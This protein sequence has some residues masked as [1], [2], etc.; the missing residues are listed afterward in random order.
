MRARVLI[1]TNAWKRR[2]AIG[3][4][5]TVRLAAGKYGS[6]LAHVAVS[7]TRDRSV[8]EDFAFD[9]QR[10]L[11]DELNAE[12]RARLAPAAARCPVGRTLAAA[13]GPRPRAP[14][15]LP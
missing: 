9:Y 4:S 12:Q 5:A 6:A 1:P 7:V 3:R 10:A 14:I 2:L 13:S 11:P 8:A 15:R